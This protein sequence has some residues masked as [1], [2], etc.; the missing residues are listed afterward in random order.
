MQHK[1]K[2]GWLLAYQVHVSYLKVRRFCFH[3]A[4]I[5]YIL[6]VS[7]TASGV[8]PAEAGSATGNTATGPGQSMKDGFH[9]VYTS[10]SD[11]KTGEG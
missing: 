11:L 8:F 1:N 2:M 10:T 7:V 3:N 5:F 6:Q 4:V 9:S